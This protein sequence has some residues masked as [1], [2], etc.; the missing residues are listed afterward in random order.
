[1][2]LSPLQGHRIWSKTYDHEAN[3]LLSLESRTVLER[4]QNL[5]RM[6]F[7]DAAC[8]TGR[9]LAQARARGASVFG[10]DFCPEMLAHAGEKSGLNGRT[11][12]ADLRRLPLPGGRADLVM[13]AFS[14]GY[15]EAIANVVHELAR[16]VRRG[17]VVIVTDLHPRAIEAGWKRS[18]RNGAEVV[19]IENHRYSVESLLEAGRAAGLELERL[20]E[21]HFGAPEQEIFRTGGKLAFF[22]EACTIPAVLIVHW[23]RP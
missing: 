21:P 10:I 17:G 22:D 8:G 5:S 9:W 7:F 2:H 11:A 15:V 6:L 14:L 18:F 16:C 4:L 20:E 19:E 3:P 23:K 13:C 12:L 1:M